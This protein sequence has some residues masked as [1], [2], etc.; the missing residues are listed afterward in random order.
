MAVFRWLRKLAGGGDDS[1]GEPPDDPPEPPDDPPPPPSEPVLG[2]IASIRPEAAY[3]MLDNGQAVQIEVA[4]IE[5]L[6]LE[7][8]ARIA[9]IGTESRADGSIWAI[10]VEA[11]DV[12]FRHREIEHPS[13][14]Q[15]PSAEE[16]ERRRV[17]ADEQLAKRHEAVLERRRQR[18]V[19]P[20]ASWD[21]L[22]EA[23]AMVL[24]GHGF[25][26]V[27]RELLLSL[28]QPA[29][30]LIALP[31]PDV[32]PAAS[33]FGGDPYL[34]AETAWPRRQ[35]EPL[36]F[37]AQ[38]RL[39]E[40]PADAWPEG[41]PRTG[42]L[43]VFGL[44]PEPAYG[45]PG[46]D[47]AWAVMHVPDDRACALAEP[48]AELDDY[49][50]F[51]P[52]AVHLR[53]TLSPP[54]PFSSRLE[55]LEE[56]HRPPDDFEKALDDYWTA[57]EALMPEPDHRI[58]GWPAIVQEEMEAEVVVAVREARGEDAAHGEWTLLLQLASDLDGAPDFMWGDMGYLYFW[59]R[60]ADLR[61]GRFDNVW[62]I[63]QHH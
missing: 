47:G 1:G 36:A 9:V 45:E 63:T 32:A 30:R 57:Y 51:A 12:A 34:P 61:A 58:G 35:D 5:E 48:P 19:K 31:D 26:E 21:A 50:R 40:L 6:G 18:L 41:A 3:A 28:A 27:D 20:A 23:A 59:I 44:A 33:R 22:R 29:V 39:D 13:P 53:L 8:H 46:D 42:H 15:P 2:S 10:E 54:S 52:C 49:G 16:Q 11:S 60:E 38:V 25:G 4:R 37:L 7:K 43:L 14:P 62:M 55:A 56:E 24:E 17:V